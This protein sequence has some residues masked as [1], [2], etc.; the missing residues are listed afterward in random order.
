MNP[1]HCS[2]PKCQKKIGEL[3]YGH[4]KLKCRKCGT[5]TIIKIEQPEPL[6]PAGQRR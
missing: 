3:A 6:S 5:I 1:I 4:A 2:N